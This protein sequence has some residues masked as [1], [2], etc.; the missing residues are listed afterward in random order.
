MDGMW[1]SNPLAF[2]RIQAAR[3][4]L[5][6]VLPP[7]PLVLAAGGQGEGQLWMKCESLQP[8]GSFKIR[9]ATYRMS[10]LS[11]AQRAHGV[12]AYSTGNHAQA[13]A[14]AAADAGLA[15]TIVMSEDAPE[16]KIRATERWGARIL[17]AKPTSA[18]RRD[19]AEEFARSTGAVLIPPYDDFDIMAGQG[20]IAC[21]LERQLGGLE[22][23]TLFIPVGGGGLIAGVAAAAKAMAPSC[24]IIGVEPE[25]E[26]D[27]AKSFRSGQL[28]RAS[29]PSLSIA[30][31]IKVQALGELTFPLVQQFVDDIVTV[32]EPEI[33]RASLDLFD[34]HHLVVEPGGAVGFASARK[35]KRAPGQ[36]HVALLC[37]GNITLE[38]LHALRSL[39]TCLL[40]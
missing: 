7:T 9:G 29:G 32:S 19:L 16:A 30:D 26:D 18:D 4:V 1:R 15:S 31:A 33:V 23:C 10:K 25:L 2:D 14:K 38:R 12:V 17:M 22:D 34:I 37:G 8:T 13:V 40:G 28:V 20:T 11:E 5:A 21:E 24:R 27:A 35:Q 36:R 3:R 6:S 39:E